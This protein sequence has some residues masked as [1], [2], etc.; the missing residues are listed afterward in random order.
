MT[1]ATNATARA[2]AGFLNAMSVYE[3]FLARSASQE[4][5]RGLAMKARAIVAHDRL[6]AGR[7]PRGS[8]A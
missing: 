4:R 7:L 3:R 6:L 1:A 5:R 2:A 8:R